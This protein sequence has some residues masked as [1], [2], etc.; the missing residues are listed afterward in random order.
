MLFLTTSNIWSITFFSPLTYITLLISFI[1]Y[2]LPT[3]TNKT[4]YSSSSNKFSFVLINSFDLFGLLLSPVIA[5][6]FL[7]SCWSAVTTSAWF[8]H[9]LL[10]PFQFKILYLILFVFSS[11]IIALASTSYFSSREFYDFMTVL[12]NFLYWLIII[13]M[14]NTIFT[15]IF[16]IEVLSTLIFLLII[17]STFSSNF[18]YRNLNLS[19]GH[20]FQ[21]STPHTYLQSLLYFFWISLVSSLNLFLF[22]L[23]LYTKILTLDWFLIEHVFS[24]LILTSTIKEIVVVGISWFVL[25]TCI[26]LKC[27][28]APLYIWK[29]TFFKGLPI[30]T[31]YIYICFFYFF[32]FLFLIQLLTSYFS[33]VFYFYSYVTTIFVLIGL[34]TLLFI[35]CDSYYIKAFLAISSILNSIFVLMAM[36]ATHTVA[37]TLWL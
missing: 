1:L 20:I 27:G 18:F 5:V 15:S 21:Q 30:H 34:V 11:V 31:I 12:Y 33:T 6:M 9:L 16:V 36:S 13:F 4:K 17:T 28:V 22:I 8:G 14:S 3:L 35:I 23:L 24:F 25:L 32:L 19:F 37:T 2:A 10:G 26:F 7:A 29:P